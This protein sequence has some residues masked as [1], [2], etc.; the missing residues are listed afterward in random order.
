MRKF[1]LIGFLVLLVFDTM[2]QISFKMTAGDA[3]PLEASLGW[4]TRILSTPWLYVA[5]CGYIGAF[6]TW[7]TLL[8]RAPVGPAFAAAHMELVTVMIA[9]YFIFN[10]QLDMPRFIGAALIIAGIIVLAFA[11][12]GDERLK[13]AAEC[14]KAV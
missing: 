14:K 2:G 13:N 7:M 9:S 11:E 3:A 1:Y 12:T 5:I 4:L 6:F 8:R 10:E